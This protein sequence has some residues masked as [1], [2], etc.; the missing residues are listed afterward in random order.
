MNLQIEL[1]VLELAIFFGKRK[2]AG[3]CNL[4]RWG[5]ALPITDKCKRPTPQSGRQKTQQVSYILLRLRFAMTRGTNPWCHAKGSQW[6]DERCC[7]CRNTPK[8][9]ALL[10]FE[11][12]IYVSV[13]L[14]LGYL[15]FADFSV[16]TRANK[17]FKRVLQKQVPVRKPEWHK[18]QPPT[19]PKNFCNTLCQSVI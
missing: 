9:A 14:V 2:D 1:F 12:R 10:R 5:S 11:N 19:E 4:S 17:L 8:R 6:H 13:R 3:R 7:S 15:K 16:R 18:R